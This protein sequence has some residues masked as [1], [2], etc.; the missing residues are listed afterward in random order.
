MP[1]LIDSGGNTGAQAVT[2]IIRALATGEITLRHWWKVVVKELLVGLSL[3]L[4]M[5]VASAILVYFRGGAEISLVV[6]HLMFC[7]VVMTNLFGVLR[8]FVLT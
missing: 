5:T 1:L 6:V 2:L 7:I 4:K 8:P 3:G